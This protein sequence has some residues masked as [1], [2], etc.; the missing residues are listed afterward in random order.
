MPHGLKDHSL[1]K[2]LLKKLKL[3]FSTRLPQWLRGKESACNAGV[4][5]EGGSIPG[6]GRSLKKGMATQSSILPGEFHVQRS[7]GG[8]T[9]HRVAKSWTGLK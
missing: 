2:E 5:G 4:A 9:V 7:L 8:Y 6:L 3:F 1:R